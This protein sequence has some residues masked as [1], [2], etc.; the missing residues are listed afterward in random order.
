[1]FVEPAYFQQSRTT[2]NR[3]CA[4]QSWELMTSRIAKV[5]HRNREIVIRIAHPIAYGVAVLQLVT[6]VIEDEAADTG[7]LV[8][9]ECRERID[10]PVFVRYGIIVNER[11]KIAASHLDADVS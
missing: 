4:K 10:Q 8:R 3:I 6:G 2:K 7:D 11:Y 1:M 5:R 9:I